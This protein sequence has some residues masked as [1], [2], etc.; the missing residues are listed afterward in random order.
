MA[1]IREQA[2][3]IVSVFHSRLPEDTIVFSFSTI[4]EYSLPKTWNESCLATQRVRHWSTSV[5]RL[6]GSCIWLIVLSRAAGCLGECLKNK[7][8]S[9]RVLIA[10]RMAVS[11]QAFAKHRLSASVTSFLVSHTTNTYWCGRRKSWCSA[12][13][14]PQ[15]VEDMQKVEFAQ[16]H[17]RRDCGKATSWCKCKISSHC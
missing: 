9:L 7:H 8:T 12:W 17:R 2:A 11:S 15:E 13:A 4:A 14:L 5:D 16:C 3:A 10:L 6:T 1:N